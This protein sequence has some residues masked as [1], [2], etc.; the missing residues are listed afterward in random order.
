MP[1]TSRR[2]I[3]PPTDI[4]LTFVDQLRK[5]D[6]VDKFEYIEGLTHSLC[7]L[8]AEIENLSTHWHRVSDRIEAIRQHFGEAAT[9][10][11]ENLMLLQAWD[12]LVGV[13]P[14]RPR[15]EWAA[16]RY[17]YVSWWPACQRILKIQEVL[18][19]L[20][21]HI[22]DGIIELEASTETVEMASNMS[23]VEPQAINLTTSGANQSTREPTNG[24]ANVGEVIDSPGSTLEPNALK[25][26]TRIDLSAT[27]QENHAGATDLSMGDDGLGDD[28]MSDDG[29]IS[30][31]A[32]RKAER[33]I[34]AWIRDHN[35]EAEIY[36]WRKWEP[37]NT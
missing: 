17:L 22:S 37:W 30:T 15:V 18:G 34:G 36:G 11:N 2:R 3:L 13:S 4:D 28:G 16:E 33:T 1:A 5:K 25:L 26:P 35:R 24:R 21:E 7:E 8:V 10:G 20:A 12:E 19:A 6:Q 9:P 31:V 32:V 23:G 27:E 29:I 14:I